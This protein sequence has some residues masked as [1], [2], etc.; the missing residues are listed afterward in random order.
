MKFGFVILNFLTSQDAIKAVES[1]LKLTN[2]LSHTISIY[3]VDNASPSKI[4]EELEATLSHYSEVFIIKNAQN[5]GFAK[6]N[7]VGI[8]AALRDKCDVITCLNNDVEF[9]TEGD[10][11]ET[12]KTIISDKNIGVIGPRIIDSKGKNQNP[13][14]KEGPSE[15]E[16]KY[17]KK[18][19]NTAYGKLRYWLTRFYLPMLVQKSKNDSKVVIKEEPISG[20]YYALHG[21]VLIFTPSFF[22]HYSG[23]DPNTFLY[24][25]ELILAEMMKKV[26]LKC[27]YS[28]KITAFHAED[29]S[30]DIY[31][32]NKSKE[33]FCLKHEYD[34]IRHLV[35]TYY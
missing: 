31:L 17:R 32:K 35:K 28:N 14:L 7:N 4:I 10:F 12:C 15:S 11:F 9:S 6:G 24:G 30:T 33:K 34:S 29:V 22:N 20:F 5:L 16:K 1:L 27:Y 26:G 21:S 8:E 18:I 3:I 23:F 25:E 13:F 2:T 19:Y